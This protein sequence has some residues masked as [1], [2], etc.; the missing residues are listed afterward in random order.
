MSNRYIKNEQIYRFE[1]IKQ[2]NLA[3][4]VH[5]SCIQKCIT[6]FKCLGF[7]IFKLEMIGLLS[8]IHNFSKIIKYYSGMYSKLYF[9]IYIF[10][11]ILIFLE[12]RYYNSLSTPKI[13][14]IFIY[15]SY[16]L[17]HLYNK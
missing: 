16:Y 6:F 5:F 13:K 3:R 7:R 2:K 17:M 10:L 14:R 4:Y 1:N 12:Y 8:I 15:I 11:I 9:S